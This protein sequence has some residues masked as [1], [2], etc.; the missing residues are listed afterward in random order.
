MSTEAM[1]PR[2]IGIDTWGTRDILD[3]MV[4][5]QLAAIAA[6]RGALPALGAAAEA[7]LPRL[8]GAGRLVY[9]GAGTSGRIAV[10]DG[11]ELPPTFNWP[12]DRLVL[13]MAGG[14]T[15]MLRSVEGAEDDERAAAA[16]V[17]AH[18]IGA[19]D[20][21]VAVAASGTTPYTRKVQAL[22]RA[23]GA[24]TIALASNRDAPLLREAEHPVLLDTGPEVIAGSTRMKAG[25]AQKAALNLLSSL[26]MIRLARVYDGLMIDMQATN[27]KLVGRAERMVCHIAG[28]E[29]AAARAALDRCSGHVKTAVL[30]ASGLPPEAAREALD[31][32]GQDLRAALRTL[33]HT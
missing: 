7:A 9:V 4:E 32:A 17:A 3:A 28:V 31:A 23:A 27:A 10:Q 20:V 24:L 19:D 26:I 6:V 16:A 29:A 11:A 22:A 25:T 8:R 30:I 12:T 14:E 5:G 21:V 15:A 2:T 1:S 33:D 18:R 13:I